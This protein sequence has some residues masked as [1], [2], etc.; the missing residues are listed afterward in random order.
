MRKTMNEI[1]KLIIIRQLNDAFN[2]RNNSFSIR[3]HNLSLN[4]DVLVY[5]EKNDNQSK[6][7]KNSFKLLNVNDESAIIEFS[8]DLTK[9]RSTMIKSYYDDDYLENSS[10]FILI[11]DFSFVAFIIASI[12]KSSNMLQSNDLFAVS[13][14]QESE[15]EIFSNSFRRDHDRF[16]NYS[17]TTAFLSFVFN[18]MVDLA[19]VSRF[20]SVVHTALSQFAAFRQKEINELIE[21]DVFQSINEN[22]V[23]TN[24]CIFNFR[25]VNEIKHFDINK[26]F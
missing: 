20:D 17:A 23:S 16:R 1:R 12:F 5:C 14:D 9:F 3:I 26:A 2:I 15:S 21:K 10:S 4:S 11:I 13:N 7:W 19:V 8:S 22:D 18:A 6:L 25:F 24:V